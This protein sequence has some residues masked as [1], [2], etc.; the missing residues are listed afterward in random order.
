MVQKGEILFYHLEKAP[1]SRSFLSHTVKSIL[2]YLKSP[3]KSISLIFISPLQMK[4]MNTYWRHHPQTTTVLTFNEGDI[5][6]CPQEIKKQALQRNLSL[7]TFYQILLIHSILHLFGYTHDKRKER[8][9]MESLEQKI[10]DFVCE[11]K[12]EQ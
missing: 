2:K 9:K 1:V 4:E 5:F 10:K 8:E 11:G 7:K 3:Q 12:P 6:L